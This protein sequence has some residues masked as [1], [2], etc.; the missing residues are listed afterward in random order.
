MIEIVAAPT[1]ASR[2]HHRVPLG[3]QH[4]WGIVLAGDDGRSSRSHYIVGASS[5]RSHLLGA[6]PLARFRR[7]LQ[8]AARL[9]PE[10]RLVA[11]LARSDALRYEPAL[12]AVP[13]ARRVVQPTYRGTGPEIFLPLMKIA[14]EDAHATVVI[15]PHDHLVDH[16]ARFMSYVATAARA[17]DVRADVPI[18]LGAYPRDLDPAYAWIDPGPPVEGLEAYSIR[19]VQRFVRRPSAADMMALFDGNGLLSTLV[20]VGK[21]ETLLEIGRACVPDVLE[22]LEP[23]ED[24]FDGPEERLMTEAVYE[25]MPEASISQ[26]VLERGERF[27]VLPIPDVMWQESGEPAPALAC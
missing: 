27:A 17:V 2:Q 18:V 10:E 25:Y 3:M 4:L 16:K 21:V 9:I 6:P 12:A 15:L 8:R 13:R 19:A 22:T 5:R 23:L 26:D 7:T 14:R 1:P 24:A 20:I 11:V